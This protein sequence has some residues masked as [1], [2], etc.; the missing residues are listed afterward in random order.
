MLSRKAPLA[1][2]L[3]VVSLVGAVAGFYFYDQL[4]RAPGAGL[5][6]PS[7]CSDPESIGSRVYHPYRLLI[8][9]S[10]TTASGTVD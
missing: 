1:V 4:K 9:K 10:C 3:V 6:S 5:S 2:A 7:S 8:V